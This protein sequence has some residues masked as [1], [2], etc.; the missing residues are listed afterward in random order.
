MFAKAIINS[1]AAVLAFSYL[2]AAAPASSP[3]LSVTAQLLVEDV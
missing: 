1:S 2:A 3:E